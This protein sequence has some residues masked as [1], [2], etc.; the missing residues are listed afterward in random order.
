MVIDDGTEIL[1]LSYL[2]NSYEKIVR[3]GYNGLIALDGFACAHPDYSVRMISE[4]R[5]ISHS[6]IDDRSIFF[7]PSFVLQVE[8]RGLYF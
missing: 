2:I 5:R 1:V 8:R 3:N 4:V 6:R 7:Q